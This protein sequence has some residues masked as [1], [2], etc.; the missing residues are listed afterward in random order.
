MAGKKEDSRDKYDHSD[1]PTDRKLPDDLHAPNGAKS[2]P[3][4]A[5]EGR[6]VQPD[7]AKRRT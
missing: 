5:E 1:H 4:N 3:P 7:P 2:S 6:P